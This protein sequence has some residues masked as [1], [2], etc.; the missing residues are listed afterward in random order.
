MIEAIQLYMA[1]GMTTVKI[2]IKYFDDMQYK[3][4]KFFANQIIISLTSTH[5]NTL[6]IVFLACCRAFPQNE[7]VFAVMFGV[8]CGPVAI[9]ILVFRNSLVYHDYD[10]M[11]S[12]YIHLMPNL[13]V[14]L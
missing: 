4:I 6:F 2:W 7:A 11:T 9:A 12:A 14:Y 1:L 10:R 3:Y 5:H 8:T 13:V